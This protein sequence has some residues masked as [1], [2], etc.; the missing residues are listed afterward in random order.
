MVDVNCCE[1][2]IKQVI[3][4]VL[5][6][7]GISLLLPAGET[8]DNFLILVSRRRG[9]YDVRGQFLFPS[10]PPQYL[11]HIGQILQ[12]IAGPYFLILNFF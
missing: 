9:I 10:Y 11:P 4:S 5:K 7:L 2:A 1:K 8:V 12:L 3:K 6:I